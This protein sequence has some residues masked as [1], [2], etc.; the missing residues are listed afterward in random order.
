[1]N[2]LPTLAI[3]TALTV[4]TFPNISSAAT[5]TDLQQQLDALKIQVSELE[6][7][8]GKLEQPA[9]ETS[10]VQS[11]AGQPAPTVIREVVIFKG[12]APPLENPGTWQD[13]MNW[14]RL[15]SGFSFKKVIALIGEPVF[16]KGGDF[17]TWYYTDKGKDGP[18]AK[19]MFKKLNTWKAPEMV[20]ENAQ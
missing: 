10:S 12:E 4:G 17:A 18:Y 15:K 20:I 3:I 9:L 7:R 2:K 16:K 1:M 19:F 13:P 8:L 6:Q 14:T 11:A 5:A